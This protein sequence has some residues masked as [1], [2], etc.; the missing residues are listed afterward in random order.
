MLAVT[1]ALLAT[2]QVTGINDYNNV[3][4]PTYKRKIQE[5]DENFITLGL[6]S[7]LSRASYPETAVNV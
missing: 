2:M 1:C 7:E 5:W 6:P 3:D 4:I